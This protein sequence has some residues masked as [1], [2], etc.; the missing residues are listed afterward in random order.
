MI[1]NYNEKGE[2]LRVRDYSDNE[3][4]GR[5]FGGED[6][7]FRFKGSAYDFNG[8]RF[9]R[10]DVLV[11]DWINFGHLCLDDVADAQE[12]LASMLN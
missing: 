5:V 10:I 1:R 11:S 6:L 9:M 3:L 12:V 8:K 2:K 4:V 7:F